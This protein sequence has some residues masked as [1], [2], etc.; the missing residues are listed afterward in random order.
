MMTPAPACFAAVFAALFVAHQVADHWVQT[1]HQAACKGGPGWEARRACAA[2]IVTYT[3]TAVV[4][5]LAMAAATGL[6]LSAGRAAAGLA[7]S[8]VTHYV[9][10][11][12]TP[13]KWLAE[14]CGSSRFYTLGAC[15]TGRD[16]NPSLGTGAYALD[17]SFHYAWL[18]VAALIIA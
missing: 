14:L 10:D 16:D 11:R 6:P 8:A 18:F 3:A 5:L 17:Q 13:L 4:A 15:R 2:H 12:R 9:A 7:V 1:D